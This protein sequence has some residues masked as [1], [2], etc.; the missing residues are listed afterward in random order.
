MTGG[1]PDSSEPNHQA[2]FAA[3]GDMRESDER[4]P[5]TVAGLVTLRL[6][7]K[8]EMAV[9]GRLPPLPAEVEAVRRSIAAAPA[10]AHRAA[11]NGIVDAVANAWG[12]R[13]P[14]VSA[15]VLAYAMVLYN[16]EEW[17]L[18]ADVYRT[19]L[20]FAFTASDMELVA[21]AWVKLGMA[22][23]MTADFALAQRAHQTGHALAHEQRQPYFERLAEHGMA[24]I[25]LQR[26]NLPAADESLEA[27]IAACRA[28]IAREPALADV[29]VRALH[30][31]GWVALRRGDTARAFGLLYDALTLAPDPRRRER[32]LH[33]L[34]TAFEQVGDRATARDAFAMVER[35]TSDRMVRWGAA[36]NLMH[37]AV[38][39]GAETTFERY[40]RSLAREPLPPRF[41][42]D[43]CIYEAEGCWRFGRIEPARAAFERAIS[44]AELHRLGEQVIE[45]EAT[46]AAL[47]RLAQAA[48][49]LGVEVA[50]DAT[51][52]PFEPEVVRVARAIRAMHAEA[53][54]GVGAEG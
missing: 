43:Y 29:L 35:E 7:D 49:S 11:L 40:R 27:V 50:E 23:T 12:Q 36:L 28:E 22:L 15:R 17:A 34:A 21:H 2:F 4:W 20:M 48:D 51:T 37:L 47:E 41:A 33:D 18:A 19:F 45:A 30:D 26:G 42:V 38:R 25:A 52:V 5:G 53:L 14:A 39:E 9:H 24:V 46:R 54:P 16:A 3:L 8:W 44:L 6:V 32:V 13:V 31:R 1:R 10:D